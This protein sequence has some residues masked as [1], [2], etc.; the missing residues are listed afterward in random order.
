[1]VTGSC[2]CGTVSWQVEGALDGMSHCHCSMCRKAHGAPF[3]T[4][5]DVPNDRFTWST[6]KDN[7][8]YFESSPG[9][10]RAFCSTCGSVV[11]EPF[12]NDR[13]VIP[14]GCLDGDPGARRS[15]PC[16]TAIARGAARHGPPRMRPTVLP[17]SMAS[18]SCAVRT[19]SNRSSCRRHVSSR[20][21]SVGAAARPCRAWIGTVTLRSFPSA[22]WTTTRDAAATI[23]ST[24][25][26]WRPGTPSPTTCRSSTVHQAKPT[27]PSRM[28]SKF[29]EIVPRPHLQGNSVP[30]AAIR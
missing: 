15:S 24:R 3:G 5:A 25:D 12:D 8:T 26:R 28:T 19:I 6:G 17:P 4:Y 29:A 1:M 22:R 7:T 9:T 14:A 27:F 13:M 2:L 18:S 20:K 16:T 10:I 11:P 21:F 30:I 23:T